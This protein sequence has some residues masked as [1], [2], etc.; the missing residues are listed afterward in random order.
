MRGTH[1]QGADKRIMM[2]V[3]KPVRFT[4]V[5]PSVT[6]LITFMTVSTHNRCCCSDMRFSHDSWYGAW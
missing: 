6:V 4:A 5:N 2:E 3:S 1:V